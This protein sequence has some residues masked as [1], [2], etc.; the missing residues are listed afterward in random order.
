MLGPSFFKG[1]ILNSSFSENGR[2]EIVANI[3]G[4]YEL[5][6]IDDVIPIY[7]DSQ[8]PVWSHYLKETW[9]LLVVKLWA[10]IKGG[11][12]RLKDSHPFELI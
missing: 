6:V 7:E 10:K 2:Y 11:Y 5:E 1:I 4:K 12:C 3:D 9:Q 8:D